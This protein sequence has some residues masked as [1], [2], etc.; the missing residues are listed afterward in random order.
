[1]VVKLTISVTA[2]NARVGDPVIIFGYLQSE[3][4]INGSYVAPDIPVDLLMNG[5]VVTSTRTSENGAYIFVEAIPKG[6]P[7]RNYVVSAVAH[8]PAPWGDI[9]SSEVIVSVGD[10]YLTHSNSMID[11]FADVYDDIVRPHSLI[12]DVNNIITN[13]P[14]FNYN[15]WLLYGFIQKPTAVVFQGGIRLWPNGHTSLAFLALTGEAYKVGASCSSIKVAQNI[16]GVV[17][18]PVV[19]TADPSCPL[20]QLQAINPNALPPEYVIRA[21]TLDNSFTFNVRAVGFGK[22]YWIARRMDNLFFGA[23]PG[24]VW[25][26]YVQ[27]T[28]FTGTIKTPVTGLLNIE[29]ILEV[30]REWHAPIHNAPGGI[31]TYYTALGGMQD[32]LIFAF[33]QCYSPSLGLPLS[34][35]GKL[36]FPTV[37]RAF[38]FDNYHLT[39]GG[40]WLLPDWYRIIGT[41]GTDGYAELHGEVMAKHNMRSTDPSFYQP[42]IHWTGKVTGEGQ[43]LAV[44]AYGVGE[45][46]RFGVPP[47][48][49][50][51]QLI[52]AG[53]AGLGVGVGYALKKLLEKH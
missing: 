44:D 21:Q 37:D 30:D 20:Q 34:Q 10:V 52:K 2:R 53:L 51:R 3:D 33:W 8:A 25:G 35:S 12:R 50:G 49:R 22:P 40:N 43:E 5:Q 4:P 16:P 14:P 7:P 48:K 18:Y 47:D 15:S 27:F 42:L 1:M 13:K 19:Y 24:W 31:Q 45:C 9:S 32:E 26:C 23:Y 39:Y 17:D 41:F 46:T 29:G 6:T 11:A 38:A 36:I 28:K